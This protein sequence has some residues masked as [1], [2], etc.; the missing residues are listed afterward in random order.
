MEDTTS[1]TLLLAM[2]IFI[3]VAAVSVA[4][5][6][7]TTVNKTIDLSFDTLNLNNKDVVEVPGIEQ[8]NQLASTNVPGYMVYA[9]VM[10][11][12]YD[13]S[14]SYNTNKEDYQ[15]GIYLGTTNFKLTRSNANQIDVNGTYRKSYKL[16]SN[17][18]VQ[19][20][21]SKN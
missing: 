8:A 13:Y 2:D 14:S 17:N 16:D 9:E 3:F 19:I 12:L 4:V 21:Y 5:T 1:K 7:M 15:T 6:L 20:I 11:G 10:S 18:N